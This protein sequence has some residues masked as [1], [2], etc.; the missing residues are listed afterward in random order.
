MLNFDD[1]INE[2]GAH[3]E[4]ERGEEDIDGSDFNVEINEGTKTLIDI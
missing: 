1:L 3:F 2:N 4:D